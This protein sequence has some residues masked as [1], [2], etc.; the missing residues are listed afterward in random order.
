M[1]QFLYL[2][3]D[4][5]E[6]KLDKEHLFL[7]VHELFDI[8]WTHLLFTREGNARLCNMH[9]WRDVASLFRIEVVNVVLHLSRCDVSIFYLPQRHARSWSLFV[10]YLKVFG[11]LF[12][13]LSLLLFGLACNKYL[14][15]VKFAERWCTLL[16]GFGRSRVE[17]IPALLLM[18][19]RRLSFYGTWCQLNPSETPIRLVRFVVIFV[20][21]HPAMS[22]HYFFL[23]YK[24]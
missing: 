9:S 24:R 20:H 14:L 13:L 4:S 2:F 17:L 21:I 7:L 6:A 10:P 1:V 11:M 8:L 22:S 12:S 3:L 15:I 5:V 16:H 19:S 18:L 23:Y